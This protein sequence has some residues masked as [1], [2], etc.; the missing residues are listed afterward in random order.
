MILLAAFLR[1]LWRALREI[2]MEP[3]YRGLLVSVIIVLG[4]GTSFY[5]IVEGWSILDSLYFSV[6]TLMTIGYGDFA[7]TKALSKIFTIIFIFVGVGLFATFIGTV[8]DKMSTS[9]AMLRFRSRQD[10]LDDEPSVED[11]AEER[12]RTKV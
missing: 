1:P 7:P 3:R 10:P 12:E 8:A 5:R 4:A 11:G 9:R 2:W 6:V